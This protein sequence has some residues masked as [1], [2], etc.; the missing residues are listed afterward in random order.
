MN[1]KTPTSYV[2]KLAHRRRVA[3]RM[4]LMLTFVILTL[5]IVMLVGQTLTGESGVVIAATAAILYIIGDK[6]LNMSDRFYYRARWAL[7]GAKAEEYVA[8][9]LAG[10][11]VEDFYVLN[12]VPSA[13]GNIDHL[14]IAKH[15]GI[16]VIETK[17]TKGR[18]TVSGEQLLLDDERMPGNPIAQTLRNTFWLKEQILHI[19]DLKTYVTAVLLFTN[20]YVSAR[21]PVKGVC[22]AR[23]MFLH[24]VLSTPPSFVEWQN[25]LWESREYLVSSLIRSNDNSAA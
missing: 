5:A 2:R 13:S 17:S 11:K 12:D 6:T 7:K 22:I 3:S 24:K 10:L 8:E 9:I 25:R 4:F 23:P 1:K 16:F 19:L 15:G 14:I 20:A 21:K 18:V